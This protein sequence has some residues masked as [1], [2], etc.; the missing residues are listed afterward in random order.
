MFHY[1]HCILNKSPNF[2]FYFMQTFHIGRDASNQI[3]LND[4][5]VSR[6]HALLTLLDN[7]Q[8]MIK[9][10]GSSN[11]TFVNG[12]KITECYLNTGDIVK[13]GSVFLNWS[14]YVT[15]SYQPVQQIPEQNKV[16]LVSVASKAQEWNNIFLSFIKPFLNTIDNGSFFRRVF[17]WIYIVIAG[18]NIAFPFYLLFKAIDSGLFKAPGK[19]VLI[20]LVLWLIIAMLCWFGFQLWWNRKEKVNQSSYAGAEFV[21]TPVYSHLIQTSG[22]WYGVVVGVLGFLTGLLS[23]LLDNEYGYYGY[24]V[25]PDTMIPMPRLF[26]TDWKMIF[27][28]PLLGFFIVFV[29]RVF[30]ELIKA[31]AVIAN[32]TRILANNS[33]NQ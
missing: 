21:A 13:C 30:S 6:H 11:G 1:Y 9:D 29:F 3:V 16:D 22:E 24:N 27:W 14:Q 10:L 19:F 2:K 32:N 4:T 23:L 12:N 17:Y 20:F 8:V 5:Q 15:R 33:K 7:G 31:L 28:G 25:Y 18:L 26:I